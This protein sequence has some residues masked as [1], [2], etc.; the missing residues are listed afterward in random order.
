MFSL[1]DAYALAQAAHAGQVDKAGHDYYSAHLVPIAE[2]LAPFGVEAEM[3]GVLHDIIEDT[4]YVADD[5]LLIGVPVIVVEAVVA[6]SRVPGEPYKALIRR[7][8]EHSLGRLVKL[9]DNAHNLA[10]NAEFAKIDP[11]QAHSMR[12]NRYLP[13]RQVLL[14]AEAANERRVLA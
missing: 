6:V 7:A 10:S 2:S 4:D 1:N 8:A 13:A 11:Q 9:A 3:A 5:L 12:D 14:A